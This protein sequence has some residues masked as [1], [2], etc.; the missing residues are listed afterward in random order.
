[1]AKREK[2]RCMLKT[3]FLTSWSEKSQE[4]FACLSGIA[5]FARSVL[6]VKPVWSDVFFIPFLSEAA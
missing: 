1:M 3:G 6:A 4:S 2:R 5:L